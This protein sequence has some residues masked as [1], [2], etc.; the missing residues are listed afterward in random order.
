MVREDRGAIGLRSDRGRGCRRGPATGHYEGDSQEKNLP[1]HDYSSGAR[2]GPLQV[3]FGGGGQPVS[4]DPVRRESRGVDRNLSEQGVIEEPINAACLSLAWTPCHLRHYRSYGC[5]IEPCPTPPRDPRLHP[6]RRGGLPPSGPPGFARG[7]RQP[8]PTDPPDTR[9][10]GG[11]PP[12]RVPRKVDD[13]PSGLG[14]PC[15]P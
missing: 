5:P 2:C 14:H 12:A 8:H 1:P 13:S 6:M 4:R 9:R 7:R 3:G 10:G 15:W 11:G